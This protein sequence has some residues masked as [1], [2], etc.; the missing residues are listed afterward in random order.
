[1]RYYVYG[2]ID[3]RDYRLRYVGRTSQRMDKRLEQHIGA[4]QRGAKSP[5]YRWIRELL[6]PNRALC[7]WKYVMGCGLAGPGERGAT[8][9]LRRPRSSGLNASAAIA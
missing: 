1:M 5:V 7:A 3:P 4:A 8:I 6:P 2:L 9:L